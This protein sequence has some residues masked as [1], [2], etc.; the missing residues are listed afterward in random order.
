M[1]NDWKKLTT[2]HSRAPFIFWIHHL[3]YF[4]HPP[5]TVRLCIWCGPWCD[6]PSVSM[7]FDAF[8]CCHWVGRKICG[9]HYLYSLTGQKWADQLCACLV[10]GSVWFRLTHVICMKTLPLIQHFS[11]LVFHWLHLQFWTEMTAKANLVLVLDLSHSF[12]IGRKEHR[13][14]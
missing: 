9:F 13:S 6:C 10:F 5:W 4:C 11:C 14:L 2:G 3:V 12:R 8:F 7:G 1:H